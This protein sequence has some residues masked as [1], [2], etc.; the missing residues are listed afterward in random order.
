[1]QLGIRKHYNGGTQISTGLVPSSHSQ[2][3]YITTI[4]AQAL[5]ERKAKT[6]IPLMSHNTFTLVGCHCHIVPTHSKSS[7][8]EKERKHE[9]LHVINVNNLIQHSNIY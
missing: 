3:L 7:M 5:V 1:M 2:L 4:P 8:F 6:I 9:I